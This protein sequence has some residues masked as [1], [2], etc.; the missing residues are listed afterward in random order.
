MSTIDLNNLFP[1][2]TNANALRGPLP[3]QA[4]FMRYALE[5]K[6]PKHVAYFGGYG[7]GKSMILCITMITQGVMF[8]GEYVIAREFMPEL[9]RTTMKLFLE[10]LPKELLVE[11]RVADAEVHVKSVTGKPAIFYF[12]GLDSPDKLD[13]L[14]LSGAAIDEASQTSEEAFL[15]L[16]GRIRSPMGLCKILL[17]GNPKGHD[18]VYKYF[19]KQDGFNESAKRNYKILIAPSTENVHLRTDYVENMLQTYSKERIQRDIMGSFDSFEGQIYHEFQRGVHVIKP[20]RIPDDWTKI[21]GAD[22]GFVNPAAFL[23]GAVDYDGNIYIYREFYENNMLIEEICKGSKKVNKK[24][25]V[26]LSGKE[27]IEGI[28]I[29][30]STRARRGQSGGSDFD[31]YLEN[32]PK[33][34]A[35][36]PANNE[37]STGIDRVKTYFKV[38]DRTGKPRMYIFDTCLNLLDEIA[39]YRYAEISPQMQGRTNEKESPRKYKDHAVDALRYLVMSRPEIP[40]YSDKNE[41]LLKE[42]TARGAILRELETFKKPKPKDPFQDY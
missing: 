27:K 42:N 10:L 7:S 36:I 41:N 28:W 12:V 1:P 33:S 8:G 17:V 4:E 23:W 5:A 35:L 20:F 13:S 31:V 15:K 19:I 38:N 30:P 16:Q 11:H 6:G 3:K 26:D 9:R 40:K 22:H 18:W 21:I 14:T 29:D 2:A 32:I 24:G 34:W 37:V 25:V 39:Q